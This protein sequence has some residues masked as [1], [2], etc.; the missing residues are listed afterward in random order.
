[1]ADRHGLKVIYDGAHAFG[2]RVNGAGIGTFGD[3][4]M[5]S[6]HATKLFHTAEGGALACRDEAM[7]ER[8]NQLKNF[9]IIDPET[10]LSIGLNGKMNEPA[11][12]ACGARLPGGGDRP[13]KGACSCIA[14]TLGD[15]DGVTMVEERQA[16]SS[17][18]C[19]DSDRRARFECSRDGVH[20]S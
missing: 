18:Q 14:C 5:L 6:F 4:T 19:R 16:S 11:A 13:E 2:T 1:M 20:R 8:I 7:R 10:V 3:I 12:S 15:I 17:Y 9:G